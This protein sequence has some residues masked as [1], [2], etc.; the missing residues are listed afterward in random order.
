MIDKELLRNKIKE[1]IRS[2]TYND[3]SKISDDTMIFK[4]GILDS[5]GLVTLISYLEEEFNIQTE[6]TDLVE[7]NFESVNAIADFVLSKN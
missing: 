6:D 3:I 1:F 4:E 5:M 2:S 7:N